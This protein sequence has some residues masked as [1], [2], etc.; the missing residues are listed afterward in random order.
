MPLAEKAESLCSPELA[1]EFGKD[2]ANSLQ[3][4]HGN[5][6]KYQ[7]LQPNFKEDPDIANYLADNTPAKIKLEKPV[8]IYQGKA[9][10]TVPY[11]IT[12]KL[13]GKM[14]SVNTDVELILK[15]DQTHSS[16]VSKN[17]SEL[18]NTVDMLMK[19]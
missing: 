15:E 11:P 6:S 10:T 14:L 1:V 12:E 5:L 13:V 4:N 19:E 18:A 8:Y 9:D 7:A 2:I 3:A 16:V 17:I